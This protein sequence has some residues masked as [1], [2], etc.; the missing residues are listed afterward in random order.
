M[1]AT[2]PGAPIG[3]PFRALRHI[4]ILLTGL[5]ALTL[6]AALSLALGAR[7]V[8]LSTVADALFGHAQEETRSW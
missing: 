7:S 6:C 2:R 1:T 8:P 3:A 4:P 5:G